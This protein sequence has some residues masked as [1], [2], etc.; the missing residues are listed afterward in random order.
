MNKNR[1]ASAVVAGIALISSASVATA[2]SATTEPPAATADTAAVTPDEGASAQ[3]P[4]IDPGDGGVYEVSLDPADFVDVV[5]NPYFPLLPGSRWVYE[6]D[7]DGEAERIEVEVLA[8]RRAIMGISAVVVRDTVYIADEIA[9]DTYDWY[10]QDVDGNVW[11]LGEDTSE[12][13]NGQ[14]INNKGAWEYGVDG[15]LPGIVM[16]AEPTLGDAYRQEYYPGEAED[17]GEIIEVDATVTIGLGV[18]TDVV[19]T[20]DWNPLEPEV[21]ENKSYAPGVGVILETHVAGGV[22]TAEL[23]EF[24]PGN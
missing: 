2:S 17:M 21:I 5:D 22:G 18:Y 20:Q 23:V 11:Y 1:T 13:E 14:P 19:V 9:E 7:S 3:P 10:A 8:E 24:T 15:A 6:G 4:V 16:P 12:Y